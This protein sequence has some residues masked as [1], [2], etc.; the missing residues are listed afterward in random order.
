MRELQGRWPGLDWGRWEV[1]GGTSV[2][3]QAPNGRLRELGCA[4]WQ[5]NRHQGTPA[6]LVG[7]SWRGRW[8]SGMRAPSGWEW[9]GSQSGQGSTELGIP[10]PALWQM[11]GEAARRTGDPSHQSEDLPPE[12]LGGHDL[13]TQADAGCPAGQVV[14]D[15]LAPPAMRRWRRSGPTACGSA[16]RRT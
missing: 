15:Y 2:T 12:G 3:A 7:A 10:R 13:L 6:E 14:R 16:R 4:G 1:G 8:V 5:E 11:Q 9:N